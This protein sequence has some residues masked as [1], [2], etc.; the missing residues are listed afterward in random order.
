[1]LLGGFDGLHIGHR[2]LLSCA[3]KE[4]LPVGVMTIVGGKEGNNLFT[5]KEREEIFRS[6]GVDFV[7]ELPF[8]EIRDLSPLEFI[9]LLIKEFNPKLFVCGEDFRFGYKAQGTPEFIKASTHVRVEMQKL[10]EIDGEKVSS[11]SVKKLLEQG[12]IEKV[13]EMLGETYFLQ[14]KVEK[15]RGVGKTIGFPT[16]N[17]SYPKDK[18]PIKKGVYETLVKVNGVAYKGIT[19]YGNR[20]TFENEKVCMETCLDGFDGNLYGKSLKIQ[21]IRY[22]R[23][24][25]KFESVDGLKAQ[26]TEDI[27]R[28]REND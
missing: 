21:F 7:F 6:A 13:N 10:V 19:N 8:A 25:K 15:D 27:R 3:K 2:R 23:D 1:M 20:P 12:K 17:I 5:F 22:L 11:T 16:A 28:I 14:G 26:L 18:F 4:G 24:I 9:R